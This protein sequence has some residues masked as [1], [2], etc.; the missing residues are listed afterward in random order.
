MTGRVAVG[1]FFK[2]L[3][4]D[5]KRETPANLSSLL[6]LFILLGLFFLAVSVSSLRF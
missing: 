3:W 2:N 1:S 4:Q 6:Y 5:F